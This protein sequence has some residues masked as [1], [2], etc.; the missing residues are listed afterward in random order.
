MHSQRQS[1]WDV[2]S[3]SSFLSPGCVRDSAIFLY[4]SS[5]PS[6]HPN[7]SGLCL[8]V[9]TYFEHQAR[10][11][12]YILSSTPYRVPL[13]SWCCLSVP[14]CRSSE[15]EDF[16]P[17]LPPT[18]PVGY[19]Q[20]QALE[21]SHWGLEGKSELIPP[22]GFSITFSFS[23]YPLPTPIQ[24]TEAPLVGNAQHWGTGLRERGAESPG[25]ILEFKEA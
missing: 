15:G 8:W 11:S 2:K 25:R 22:P 17:H 4:W 21:Q 20:G 13:R 9:L 1:L 5:P 19:S 24:R 23:S 3:R 10:P 12:K 14:H 6:I 18:A 7:C 16:P